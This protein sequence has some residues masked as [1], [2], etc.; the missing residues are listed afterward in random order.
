VITYEPQERLYKRLTSV[1][2]G[3]RTEVKEHI[4]H[5]NRGNR[6][7]IYKIA[8]ETS[9]S[10]GTQWYKNDLGLN[11]KQSEVYQLSFRLRSS[12]FCDVTP[13]SPLKINRPKFRFIKQTGG[14]VS[15]RCLFRGNSSRCRKF[16]E[17]LIAYFPLIRHGSHRKRNK[18]FW[19][20]LVADFPLIRHGSHRKRNKKFWEELI[21]YFPWHDTGH[22]ENDASNNSSIV[23]CVFVR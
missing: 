1:N 5:H 6:M 7:S 20:E 15:S 9:I 2:G 22:I 13:F 18:T 3:A 11:R 17:E 14:Q 19:E 10:H 12:V 8:S 21:A 4:D 23:S 16:W